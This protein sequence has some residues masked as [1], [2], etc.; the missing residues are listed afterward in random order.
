MSTVSSPGVAI[1]SDGIE[2]EA[3]PEAEV[4]EDLDSVTGVPPAPPLTGSVV[5]GTDTDLLDIIKF[6]NDRRVCSYTVRVMTISVVGSG[7]HDTCCYGL[8]SCHWGLV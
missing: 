6:G 5:W 3:G 7:Y 4:A 1:D 2:G 8:P